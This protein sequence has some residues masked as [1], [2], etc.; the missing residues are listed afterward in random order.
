[1][2]NVIY[3]ILNSQY[4]IHRINS[5]C[6][7]CNWQL[8]CK[9]E[10]TNILIALCQYVCWLPFPIELHHRKY[11]TV[12]ELAGCTVSSTTLPCI[13]NVVHFLKLCQLVTS[14]NEN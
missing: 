9:I 14:D 1:M 5:K 12:G 2:D 11:S 6:K 10:V 4:K 13:D 3:T 7:Y 8:Y